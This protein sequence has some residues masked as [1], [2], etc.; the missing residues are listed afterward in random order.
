MKYALLLLASAGCLEVPPPPHGMCNSSADCATGEVCEE[1]VCWGNPPALE[2]A[3]TL[4]PPSDRTDLVS[5]EIPQLAIPADGWVG[6]LV[7]HSPA[8]LSGRVE[9]YC[10]SPCDATNSVGATITISRRALFAGGPGFRNVFSSKDGVA[11][12]TDSFAAT[13]PRTQDGDPDYVV[14]VVPDGRGD[15]PQNGTSPAMVV[16]PLRTTLPI[17]DNTSMVFTLGSATSKTVTGTL[18]DGSHPLSQ[19]RVVALGRWDASSPLT[20]VSTVDYVGAGRNGVFSLTLA[21]GIVGTVAIVAKPYAGPFS[22]TLY[23]GN[24]VPGTDR[25]VFQIANLPPPS[26]VPVTVYGYAGD[27]SMKPVSG[28][29]VIV[30]ATYDPLVTTNNTRATVAVEAITDPNGLATLTL[31]DDQRFNA[32]YTLSVVPPASSTF[33]VVYAEPLDIHAAPQVVQL[34]NRFALRGVVVDTTGTPISNVSVTARPSLRFTWSLD[35][36][37]QQFL[38]EIPAATAVTPDDG[39]F[40][41]WVDPFL[42]DSWASFDLTCEPPMGSPAPSWTRPEIDIETPAAG[43]QKSLSLDNVTIPDASHIH[44]RIADSSGENVLGGEVRIFQVIT[45]LTLCGEVAHPPDSCAIPAQLMGHGTSDD[46]GIA[47]LSLPRP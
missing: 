10:P 43:G 16:P 9:A 45:D 42:A 11:R 32:G 39:S 17:A 24:V 27:G 33:G 31:L 1:S 26:D 34:P 18:T 21:D 35:D 47:R 37:G 6:D 40:I 20:E 14:T 46:A 12:G 23:L 7:V 41:V 8:T 28:A 36:T 44:G 22:P 30:S 2:F 15:Q 4:G 19:Y 5:T 3:A 13:L 38:A 29:R 25:Q